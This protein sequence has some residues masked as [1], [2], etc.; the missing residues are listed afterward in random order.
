M[1][2]SKLCSGPR[3]D[4]DPRLPVVLAVAFHEAAAQRLDDHRRGLVEAFARF[5][6]A[7]AEGLEFPPRQSAPEAEAEPP[8]AQQVEHRG[9][10]GDAQ[11]VVP[12][13]DDCGGADVDVR[14]KL[15]PG[16]S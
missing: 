5:V 9:I 8:V 4:L 16:V 7:D 15:P 1:R 11:R 3:A 6:H 2:P 10:L 12:G 13:Q 14:G